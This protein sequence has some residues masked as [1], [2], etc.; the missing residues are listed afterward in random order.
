MRRRI[1]AAVA[2]FYCCAIAFWVLGLTRGWTVLSEGEW[3]YVLVVLLHAVL[4]LT[5]VSQKP[6]DRRIR[7]FALAMALSTL[8]IVWPVVDMGA[9]SEA[10]V[11]FT[12][13]GG[14]LVYAFPFAAY[15]HLAT[16]VPDEHAFAGRNRWF[17]P[18]HYALAGLIG[19]VTA[20]LYAEQIVLL[21]GGEHLSWL[22]VHP[23]L[24][25]LFH[26]D[27]LVIVGG[28]AYSGLFA[29]A[30][31]GR[32][33]VRHATIRGRRQALIVFAGI[34]PWTIYMVH[35][36]A[37]E[38]FGAAPLWPVEA[39]LVLEASTVLAWALG[40]FVAVLGYQ[41]FEIG[42]VVRKGLIYSVASGLLIGLLYV[43]VLLLG[44][45]SF[46]VFSVG[47]TD[48]E[49][50]VALVFV[51]MLMRPVVLGATRAIDVVFFREKLRLERLQRNLIPA[52]AQI[53]N[54]DRAASHLTGRIRRSLRLDSAALLLPDDSRE[55]YRVRA[56]SGTFRAG[57]D[58][59]GAV[60]VGQDLRE[61]WPGPHRQVLTRE[62]DMRGRPE[63]TEL[64]R[65]LDLLDARY[66]VP[67][68]L[69]PD[70]VAVLT[71]GA[72]RPRAAF[73]RDDLAELEL[74]A[75]Q[76]SAMLENARLFHLARHDLLTGLVRRRVFEERL[77]LE[78]GR[79]RRE[80]EPFAVAMIDID[81]FKSVN[82]RHGHLAGDRVLRVIA[83]LMLAHCR[84][85]DV[86]A[87]YGGEEFVVLLPRTEREGALTVAEKLRE[88]VEG[89]V[90]SIGEG[91]DVQVTLSIGVTIIEPPDVG[92][93]GNE[94]IRRADHAL[95][96]AKAGGKNQVVLFGREEP[97]NGGRADVQPAPRAG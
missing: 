66:V 33:A 40:F 68:E 34:A 42:L 22:P 83:D 79:V 18:A 44:E 69:G 19:V 9:A 11:W 63:C 27:A 2:A 1:T 30:L 62:S 28:Y 94:F 96:R 25:K 91:V 60:L 64:F 12:A 17:V 26:L 89:R 4:S 20:L 37:R 50:G 31:L 58:A 6:D 54:L 75:Q 5:A 47:L 72:G 61:C 23:D 10:L 93:D 41:L 16:V 38:A 71:L 45:L 35:E 70:L 92:H 87:R 73:D 36:F 21:Q 67:F 86:V 65:M 46:M 49:M 95:Y 24:S 81:D 13:V 39:Q 55:F 32:A 57:D 78:L 88:A 7:V 48:W 85:T 77:S 52:L 84:S 15:V 53:T 74:L 3:L 8:T 76:A 80:F 51:G 59:R 29:L 82:D 43:L 14:S 56:L 90:V 97:A